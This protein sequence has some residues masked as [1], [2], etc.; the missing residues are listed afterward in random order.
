MT[1]K[2][3]FLDS[4]T[5]VNPHAYRERDHNCSSYSFREE[6]YLSF[7]TNVIADSCPIGS[8]TIKGHGN[9]LDYILLTKYLEVTQELLTREGWELTGDHLDYADNR[10]GFPFWTARKG[11]YNLIIFKDFEGFEAHKKANALCVRLK[12]F[13]REDRI[14]VFNAVC[15]NRY[16]GDKA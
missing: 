3:D 12:L 14:A 8:A 15:G 4:I 13:D 9:D 6:G 5:L 2:S 7:D 16:K 10:G 11:V 1:Y